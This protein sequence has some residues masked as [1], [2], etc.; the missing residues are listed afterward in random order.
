MPEASRTAIRISCAD[1]ASTATAARKFYGHA[2]LSARVWQCLA[3]AGQ[4]GYPLNYFAIG[5][6]GRVP[7]PG[8]D[9]FVTLDPK[10]KDALGYSGTATSTQ[11]MGKT[12]GQNGLSYAEVTSP[13]ILDEMKLG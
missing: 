1:I 2:F 12:I 10:K 4:E 9:N 8:A 3:R 13:A 6:P 11:V 5:D 7:S